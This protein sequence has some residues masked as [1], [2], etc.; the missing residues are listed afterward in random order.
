[1]STPTRIGRTCGA[2]RISRRAASLRDRLLRVLSYIPLSLRGWQRPWMAEV[3]WCV[4]LSR[5]RVVWREERGECLGGSRL[6]S[7]AQEIQIRLH[8]VRA[9]LDWTGLD[10]DGR[11][12]SYR[13]DRLYM[14]ELSCCCTMQ[15]CHRPRHCRSRLLPS[16]SSMAV[17]EWLQR[18]LGAFSVVFGSLSWGNEASKEEEEPTGAKF[19]LGW[20]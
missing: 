3:S 17:S 20:P 10:C 11:V 2:R 7:M 8:S 5:W 15:C 13:Q 9:V 12:A 1:M 14:Q 6:D 4:W 18:R 16:P 19:G